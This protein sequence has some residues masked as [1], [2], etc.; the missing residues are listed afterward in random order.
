[1]ITIKNFEEF[2]SQSLTLENFKKELKNVEN[3]KNE[4]INELR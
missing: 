1:M 3:K 2:L 4:E